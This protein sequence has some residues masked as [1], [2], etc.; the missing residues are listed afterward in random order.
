MTDSIIYISL[1]YNCSPRKYIYNELNIKKEDGYKTCPFDLCI[2]SYDALYRCLE[3]N[4]EYF[5]DNLHLIPG[6]NAD[7]DRSNCGPGG[8]NISNAYGMIFNHE[9]STHSH[10]FKESPNDDDFYIRNNFEKFK[11]R[12]QNRINNFF[13]YMKEFHHIVFIHHN[14]ENKSTIQLLK[15]LKTKYPNKII[16]IQ[17]I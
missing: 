3:T 13:L 6:M 10:N 2:T 5:F 16:D 14:P 9:G 15:L 17:V 12:Y 8:Q 7:G 4:F 11:R 1:G